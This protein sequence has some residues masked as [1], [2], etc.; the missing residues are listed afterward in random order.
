MSKKITDNALRNKIYNYLYKPDWEV[1]DEHL[2]WY[3]S[4]DNH[5]I[6]CLDDEAYPKLLKEIPA[7]PKILFV[8]GNPDFLHLPQIAI[9]GSRHPTPIG[10]ESA[11][12]FADTLS[13]AELTVTSGLALGIDG[14]AH[15][16]AL[17][18]NKPT[19]AVLGTG[20]DTI[21]PLRH[22]KLR[23]QIAQNGAIVSEYPL[24][25]PP[26]R[27]N[28]PKRNRIISGLSLGTLVVEA[29]TQSGSLIT[30]NLAAEQG[31]EVF[32][33]PGS[34]HCP[35]ARGCHQLINI[36]AKLTE[37]VED[38]L[39]ELPSHLTHPHAAGAVLQRLNEGKIITKQSQKLLDT[40]DYFPTS[41]DTIAAR[42]GLTK[43]SIY[44]MLL[45][46]ELKGHICSLSSGYIRVKL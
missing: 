12:Y 21:Y 28:F 22:R 41:F 38:I 1:V 10:L 20:V 2:Q 8:I 26:I 6:I 39:E 34:I 11:Y 42:S 30:A 27:H 36:G 44:S 7:P 33:I 15:R 9:V 25:T 3:E 45:N 32:A 16:G 24:K 43:D 19:I 4:N 5:H 46:L 35:T 40:I 31:R 37:N 23:E 14:A 13:K 18:A 29:T 17:N